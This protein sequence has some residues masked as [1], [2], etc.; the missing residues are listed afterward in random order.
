M[1]NS[2]V[3]AVYSWIIDDVTS[4]VGP[5][6]ASVGL[7]DQT[8]KDIEKKWMERLA[9]SG[10]AQ[11]GNLQPQSGAH[12][13]ATAS[14]T[15]MGA[16]T[17]AGAQNGGSIVG[18]Y[19]GGGV[20]VGIG[21]SGGMGLGSLG[22]GGMSLP[23]PQGQ[24]AHLPLPLPVPSGVGIQGSS[25]QYGY[26]QQYDQSHQSQSSNDFFAQQQSQYGAPQSQYHQQSQ[27][28]VQQQQ[29]YGDF[30]VAASSGNM[31]ALIFGTPNGATAGQMQL[32]PLQQQQQYG[33]QQQGYYLP[34][35]D[36]SDAV[37]SMNSAPQTRESSTT[38][39][40]VMTKLEIDAM[41]VSGVEAALERVRRR[42][43]A[44]QRRHCS[45]EVEDSVFMGETKRK[46]KAARVASS[47]MMAGQVDGPG[48]DD[49]DDDEDDVEGNDNIGS[50]LDSNDD[51]DDSDPELTDMILC[52]YEKVNRTKNKWKCV[53]KDGIVHVN[54]KD[55]LFHKASADFEW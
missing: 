11:F 22:M 14:G 33:R 16:H 26:Q 9:A 49:D 17:N 53:F 36:G 40:S 6:F 31:N 13:N 15:G 19:N 44:S 50:D 1:S 18:G 46:G 38:M 51:D 54:G 10:C 23:L 25:S 29:G 27:Y 30:G 41:L 20:G 43:E 48:D 12:H 2:A 42:K 34:Q 3:P 45:L 4:K 24:Q 37:V 32:P 39:P 7:S 8:L 52:Q 55:Y 21:A 35:N 28:G 47:A 5:Y